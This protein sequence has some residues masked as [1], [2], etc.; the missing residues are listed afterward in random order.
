MKAKTECYYPNLN[1][2]YNMNQDETS[3]INET[4]DSINAYL[5]KRKMILIH[6][7]KLMKLFD[8]LLVL[9]YSLYFYLYFL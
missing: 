3:N 6:L 5:D 7:Q 2:E 8:F 4:I 1:K 9:M